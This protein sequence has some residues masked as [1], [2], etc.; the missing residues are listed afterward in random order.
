MRH[1]GRLAELIAAPRGACGLLI[2]IAQAYV[3]KP[4][5]FLL[6]VGVLNRIVGMVP[7]ARK[8]LKEGNGFQCLA[9]MAKHLETTKNSSS[10]IGSKSMTS[11]NHLLAAENTTATV[12]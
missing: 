1:D 12:Q 9:R 3:D 6:V 4:D 7:A 2:S 5:I 8:E 11:L 10:K